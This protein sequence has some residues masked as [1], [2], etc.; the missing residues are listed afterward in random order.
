MPAPVMM[1]LTFIFFIT[2]TDCGSMVLWGVI[3]SHLSTNYIL[4][5]KILY[6]MIRTQIYF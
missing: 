3:E 2:S 4:V 6:G 5:V 1:G